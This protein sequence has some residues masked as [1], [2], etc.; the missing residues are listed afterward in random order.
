MNVSRYHFLL[1]TL[2]LLLFGLTW[3]AGGAGFN[4]GCAH[5]NCQDK[6]QKVCRLVCEEKKVNVTCWGCTCEEFCDPG[7]GRPGCWHCEEVCGK[8]NDANAPKGLCAEPKAFLWREW[9]PGC[10][11]G[12]LHKKKLMKKV[13]VKKVPTYKWVIEDLCQQ[14]E[15]KC[16]KVAVLPGSELPPLPDVPDAKLI[17]YTEEEA[18]QTP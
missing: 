15:A 2:P 6:C 3:T 16:E 7:P 9:I 12:I 11:R 10:A 18:V 4:R 17:G 8:C 1:L 13:I 5:C 14:C